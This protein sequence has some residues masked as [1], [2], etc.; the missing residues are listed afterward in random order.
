MQIIA[1]HDISTTYD[2]A[3]NITRRSLYRI[4]TALV[5]AE[6]QLNSSAKSWPSVTVCRSS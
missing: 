5:Q 6:R 4:P 1:S 3:R 2:A